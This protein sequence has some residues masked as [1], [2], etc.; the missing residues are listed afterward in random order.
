M[1]ITAVNNKDELSKDNLPPEEIIR[2]VPKD[3]SMLVTTDRIEINWVHTYMLVVPPL[4]GVIGL[5][6]TPIQFK[7]LVL[8]IV[9]YFWGGLGITGGYHRLWAHK[10]YSAKFPIRLLLAIGGAAAFEGSIKWWS[11]NHRAH[12]RYTDT[13]KDPYNARR[14]FFYSHLGWMLMKQKAGQVGFADITDL[15]RDPLVRWQH[16]YYPLISITAGFVFPTL[17]A[18]LWGDFWGGLFYATAMRIV[19]IHHATFFVNSLAHHLG[20]KTFSDHHTAFDSFITALLTLGEGYHNYHHE[21][22]QDY[23][24][25]IRFF[26]YDPTKWMIGF[27]SLFGWAYDLKTIAPEEVKKAR[28]QME[29]RQIDQEKAKLKLGK[30]YQNLPEITMDE[31]NK[32]IT[33][34][35]CL[36]IINNVVHDVKNFVHEHPGGRQTLLNFVGQDVTGL[37]NGTQAGTHKHTSNAANYLNAMRMAFIKKTA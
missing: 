36:V 18:C 27:F 13:D 11:R 7:T 14:G 2:D 1:T 32:R 4:L 23:R 31:F 26:H 25:G 6:T 16:K 15:Q 28:I 22:P 20:D 29:Q 21:F 9:M 17:F 12:H 34:G 8:A 3:R 19:F 37:F 5:M 35:E 24:N 30:K 33:K 10:A